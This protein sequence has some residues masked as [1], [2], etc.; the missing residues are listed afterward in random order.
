MFRRLA[1]KAR[2]QPHLVAVHGLCE[3]YTHISEVLVSFHFWCDM[4]SAHC[5]A[6]IHESRGVEDSLSCL[7]F[8]ARADGLG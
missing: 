7:I 6:W 3:R 1:Q 5:I 8:D 4:M 2:S